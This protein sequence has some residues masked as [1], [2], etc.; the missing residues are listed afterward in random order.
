MYHLY[1]ALSIILTFISVVSFMLT[2]RQ[3][4]YKIVLYKCKHNNKNASSEGNKWPK[5]GLCR[6][7]NLIVR[8]LTYIDER[9]NTMRLLKCAISKLSML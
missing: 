9:P 1:F 3:E 2:E 8:I 7:I 4:N 5:P 6:Y